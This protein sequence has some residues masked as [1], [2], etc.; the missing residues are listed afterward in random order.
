MKKIMKILGAVFG[1]FAA[2]SLTVP[3]YAAV[4]VSGSA[5]SLQQ[6]PECVFGPVC[7]LYSL[8]QSFLSVWPW[9][10]PGKWDMMAEKTVDME[11]EIMCVIP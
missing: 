8:H 9:L 4:C 6:D 11:S 5:D 10:W 3:S 1:L 7:L 2:I